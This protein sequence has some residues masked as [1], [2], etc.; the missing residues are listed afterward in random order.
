VPRTTSQAALDSRDH[1]DALRPCFA[2]STFRLG[3][4]RAKEGTVQVVQCF[5]FSLKLKAGR[6]GARI[7][8]AI[9]PDNEDLQ[10]ETCT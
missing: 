9:F 2:N 8:H 10:I 3:Y 7:C 6:N 5:A 1:R 4:P